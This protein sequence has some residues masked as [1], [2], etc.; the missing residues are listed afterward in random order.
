[1]RF[2]KNQLDYKEVLLIL[3]IAAFILLILSM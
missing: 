2:K 3:I 1:M